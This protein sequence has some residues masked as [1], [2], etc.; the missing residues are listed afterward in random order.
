M[1]KR[2]GRYLK[3]KPR[4]V[5]QYKWQGL[6]EELEGFTDSNWAG[7]RNTGKST[8]GGAMRIGEHLI[9]AWSRTQQCVTM[10]SAEAELVAM[11]KASAEALGLL[12][13]AK[14]LGNEAT[15]KAAIL[16]DSSAALAVAGRKG[17][18]KLRHI[19]VGLLWIQEK[20]ENEELDYRKVA[21]SVNSA[22]LMT[23][24]VSQTVMEGHCQ[25]LGQSF[26]DGRAKKA[27]KAQAKGTQ[28]EKGGVVA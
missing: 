17:C 20:R 10:S 8:S 24:H 2:I 1:I 15:R 16:G 4:V 11:V 5:W 27:F 21:G 28:G 25:R 23:K 12:S 18:G 19:N 22:D 7:C 6:E 13:M 14:D 26:R 3:G 9:K